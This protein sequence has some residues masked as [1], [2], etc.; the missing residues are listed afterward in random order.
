MID[1]S[2]D[3]ALTSWVD[4]PP[5]HDFPIQN[6]PLGVFSVGGEAPRVGMAIGDHV[7]DLA[8]L[9][10]DG[11]IDPGLA[12]LVAGPVLN[13]LL[14]DAAARRLMRT[15]VSALLVTS[16]THRTA[17]SSRLWSRDDVT[18]DLPAAIGDYTD[19]YVG[20]HHA[21]AIG[22]LF[23]PDQP[24]LPNY[25]YVPIGYHGRASTVRVSGTPVVRPNGQ[26]KPPDGPPTY[27]PSR[28]L[29]FE[30]EL[31]IWLG[32]GNAMGQ[33]IDIADAGA[34]VAGLG[35][36]NDWSARD[37]QAWEYVPLGPFLAKSFATTVSPWIVTAEA[38]APF[39]IAQA[40]RPDGDP[41]PLD[42]LWDSRDQAAGAFAIDLF[43]DLIPAGGAP[44]RITRSAARHMYWT[45]A[46]MIAH[47]TSNGCALNP[48]DLLGSGTI[49]G[50]S[51]EAAA[52]LVE[53]TAGGG[54]PLA[55]AGGAARTFLEDGDE[56][57]LTARANNDGYASIGFGE[58]RG[59]VIPSA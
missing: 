56:V 12:P 16:A 1:A 50:P 43:A 54:A 35:L 57:V 3:P 2:H 34:A 29:D 26:R 49:S 53:L 59:T 18:L 38:L 21:T 5:G 4:V 15:Q 27:G 55:L 47:H 11:A 37:L 33:A 45:A 41:K 24:L 51:P 22:K 28:R 44:T 17:T 6:L 20:I 9:A 58:C 10:A 40:E 13:P 52:S 30:L 23:R 32:G 19:F 46:Q 48:G 31:A 8:G 7:V 42:Y 39:R 25:K 14:A 36:L